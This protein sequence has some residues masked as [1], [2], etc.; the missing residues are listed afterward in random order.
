M[1]NG[2]WDFKSLSDDE[3]LRAVALMV[4]S[5]RKA[6]ARMVAHLAEVEERRL[7][8]KIGCSSL[9]D[10]CRSRLGFSEGSD[11]AAQ[12]DRYS[13]SLS[14]AHVRIPT[15][16][17]RSGARAARPRSRPER[18]RGIRVSGTSDG[19]QGWSG[20]HEAPGPPLDFVRAPGTPE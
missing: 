20:R 10:Y 8:L 4:G 18:I 11:Q 16:L 6:I 15:D 19:L 9:F 5:E 2:E 3:L 14:P 1:K 12:F 17:V 13:N 7:H